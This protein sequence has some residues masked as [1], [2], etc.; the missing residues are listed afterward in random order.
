MDEGGDID[1][2]LES[3]S[4]TPKAPL[5]VG[6]RTWLETLALGSLSASL[7]GCS[8][9]SLSPRFRHGVASGD[10]GPDRV[11][12]MTR[13]ADAVDDAALEVWVAGDPEFASE[14][15]R[16]PCEARASEDHTVHTTVDGLRPGTRYFY[17]FVLGTEAS[18]IGRVKT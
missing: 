3:V 4:A 11:H 15:I 10:P 5:R 8:G 9:L 6:R 16:Q 17:R 2:D 7:G 1:S 14:V 13:L 12:L 18:A